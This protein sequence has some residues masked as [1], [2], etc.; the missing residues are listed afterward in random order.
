MPTRPPR[1]SFQERRIDRPTQPEE[2]FE[3][4]GLNDESQPK[5][6]GLFAR[7]GDSNNENTSPSAKDDSRPS[8]SHRGF[9]LI[10]GRKRGQSGVGNELK[11]IPKESPVG[12]NGTATPVKAE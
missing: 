10:P 6:R 7:F 12:T 4:V 3:D 1:A 9:S 5:K 8:S 11:S 2:G